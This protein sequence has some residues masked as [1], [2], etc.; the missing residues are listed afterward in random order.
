MSL[1]HAQYPSGGLPLHREHRNAALLTD[2]EVA[3]SVTDAIKLSVGDGNIF[4]RLPKT[5]PHIHAR[6]GQYRGQ[7]G[8]ASSWYTVRG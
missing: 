5:A 6:P 2:L 3:Y 8:E 1:L 4:N 7:R